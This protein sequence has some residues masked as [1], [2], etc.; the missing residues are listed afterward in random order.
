MRP[1][2][3]GALG[4]GLVLALLAGVGCEK[5]IGADFGGVQAVSCAHVQPPGPP[6][7]AQGAG[8]E[9]EFVFALASADLGDT[10]NAG[11]PGYKSIGY[12]V[13]GLCTNE[14]Q[15]P[16]CQSF[17]W[18]GADPTDGFDGR[19]NAIGRLMYEEKAQFGSA[20]L[21]SQTLS[22][23]IK[24][25]AIAPL[26]IVRVRNYDQRS[27]D[28]QVDVDWYTPLTLEEAAGVDGGEQDAGVITPGWDGGDVWPLQPES[29]AT[30]GGPEGAPYPNATSRDPSAYV[31]N[32]TVV[33]HLPS[34]T[35][36]RLQNVPFALDTPILVI[37]LG[38]NPFRVVGGTF[39]ARIR[40][41]ELFKRLP[42]VTTQFGIGSICKG[43]P[44]YARIKQYFCSYAEIRDDGTVDPSSPCDAVSVAF[45]FQALPVK[46]G[47]TV[48]LPP[49]TFC[50]PATSPASDTCTNP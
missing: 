17:A 15:G 2:L 24:N 19:D 45:N 18:S 10:D 1:L 22:D 9:A 44:G 23:G 20:P 40:L 50:P 36:L 39:S 35:V 8:G 34:G 29:V 28:D 46:L 30:D 49:G 4:A 6:S 7:D 31:S 12:D 11:V 48:T 21:S 26:G 42:E 14:S 13:D 41:T 27:D 38:I 43:D 47:P 3:P 33:S 37:N 32:Y 5:I 16:S 25:G